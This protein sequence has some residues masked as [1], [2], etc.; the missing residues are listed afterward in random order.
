MTPWVFSMFQIDPN[1][2]TFLSG[3]QRFLPLTTMYLASFSTTTALEF[4][5]TLSLSLHL[6]DRSLLLQV[7]S[8]ASFSWRFH[9]E[10]F[11]FLF[12]FAIVFACF[13]I[14]F[15]LSM[16]YLRVPTCSVFRNFLTRFLWD[17]ASVICLQV[18]A[19]RLS[20]EISIGV[21]NRSRIEI[22]DGDGQFML[23]VF[24]MYR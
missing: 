23:L 3:T 14:V 19:W 11:D 7:W 2:V 20:V 12:D 8:R 17:F 24:L 18:L 15:K 4:E 22:V 6:S 21:P 5:F 16:E 9:G 13:V 10:I 1:C